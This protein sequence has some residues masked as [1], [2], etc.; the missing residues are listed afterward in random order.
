MQ[1][2]AGR[3]NSISKTIDKVGALLSRSSTQR[4]RAS[5]S[6]VIALPAA[7][8]GVVIDVRVESATVEAD[9][10]QDKSRYATVHVDEF[11]PVLHHRSSWFGMPSSMGLGSVATKAKGLT[12]K[13]RRRSKPELSISETVLASA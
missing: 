8:E 13:F 11:Q 1:T 4:K 6:S 12:R 2:I 9:S 5:R 10:D 3:R 7:N